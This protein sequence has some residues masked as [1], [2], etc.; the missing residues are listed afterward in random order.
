MKGIFLFFVFQL[1]SCTLF[2]Q[3]TKFPRNLSNA[4][5]VDS[6]NIRILYALNA[7]DITDSKTYD[8][9]QQL[10][11]GAYL[12]KYYS[13]FICKSDSSL[14]DWIIKHPNPKRYGHAVENPHFTWIQG[15]DK[16]WSEYYWS[17]YFKDFS[18]NVL[19]EYAWMPY[20][21]PNYQYSEPLPVQD[22][23]MHD[24]TLTV[25]GYLCQKVTCRFRGRDYTAWFTPEIP[26]NNGPW[27]F[28]GLP[29]LILK[30]F[31]ADK[32]YTFECVGIENLKQKYPIKMF[33]LDF[34]KPTKREKLLQLQKECHENYRKV[35]GNN[36]INSKKR[37]YH[38][39]E[40]E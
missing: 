15:K 4:I 28:G 33:P 30:V 12:S 40:I 10:E 23:I 8:D 18:Q 2:T 20:L 36:E 16:R 22:W 24:D 26:I 7:V 14:T 11:V 31:D 35:I 5:I 19:S 29:G 32:L 27:K 3:A 9:L 1:V 17:D 34:Y 39:L 37:T 38:P 25:V 21:V 6:G 13:Y